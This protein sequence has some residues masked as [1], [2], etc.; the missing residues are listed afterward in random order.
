MCKQKSEGQRLNTKSNSLMN[1][2]NHWLKLV[3]GSGN[4]INVLIQK[5]KCQQKYR[6]YIYVK[7]F[8][9]RNQTPDQI[10][11]VSEQ[12]LYLRQF[13]VRQAVVV[14]GKQGCW[15]QFRI[16]GRG[17][18]V[19]RSRAD[20]GVVARSRQ[21]RSRGQTWV[22]ARQMMTETGIQGRRRL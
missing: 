5:Y 19:G 16:D 13:V 8:G 17:K 12:G 2:N 22:G 11:E 20:E 3:T 4:A 9:Q 1:L 15:G 6:N 10:Q 14:V 21:S 18:G 7:D